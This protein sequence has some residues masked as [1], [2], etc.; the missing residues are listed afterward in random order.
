MPAER[1]LVVDADTET[2][3]LI[4]RTLEH[5]GFDVQTVPDCAAA[6]A[7]VQEFHPRLVISNATSC[8]RTAST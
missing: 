8:G 1:I 3:P 2:A 4:S 7:A 5:D 6:L